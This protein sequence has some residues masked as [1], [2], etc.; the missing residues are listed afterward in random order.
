[1][2]ITKQKKVNDVLLKMIM[3]DL[4]PFSIVDDLGFKQ[5]VYALDPSYQLPSRT[6]LSRTLLPQLYEDVLQKAK[7][8]L[9]ETEFVSLTTDRWTSMTTERYVSLTAHYIPKSWELKSLLLDCIPFG[10]RHTGE[11]LAAELKRV[12][13]EWGFNEKIVGVVTDGAANMKLAIRLTKWEHLSCFAHTINLGVIKG[14]KTVKQLQTKVKNIV[15]DFHRSTV[16]AH[17]LYTVQEQ[18]SNSPPLKLKNEV[19]TRWN[20]TY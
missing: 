14:L 6:T 2:S 8:L 11:N 9:S 16:A 10:E 15:E 4:Q 19:I 18:L 12:V 17:K 5:F 13:Q 7:L 20:S 1:M 3:K